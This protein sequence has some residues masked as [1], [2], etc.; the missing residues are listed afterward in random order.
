MLNK[1]LVYFWLTGL[2]ISPVFGQDFGSAVITS[3]PDSA[4]V[5]FNGYCFG[6]TPL[7]ANYMIPGKYVLTLSLKGYMS[8]TKELDIKSGCRDCQDI[9]LKEGQDTIKNNLIWTRSSDTTYVKYKKGDSVAITRLPELLSPIKPICPELARSHNI[10]GSVNLQVLIGRDSLPVLVVL[11]KS[12]EA[13]C[14]DYEALKAAYKLKF[15]PALDGDGK[16][17]KVWVMYPVEF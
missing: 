9:L 10:Q 7:S 17:I 5:Y 14:L 1:I 6:T 16:P 2:C 11:A 4:V 15:N 13:F 12:S 8:V 3:V